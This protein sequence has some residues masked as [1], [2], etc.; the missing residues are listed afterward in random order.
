MPSSV[1]GLFEAEG[2]V[3]NGPVRWGAPVPCSV[4]GVYVVSLSSDPSSTDGMPSPTIARKAFDAWVM[5]APSLTLDGR[6]PTFEQA[7]ERLQTFWLPDET[8]IYIGKTSQPV[9]HRVAQYYATPIGA[10]KPHRGGYWVKLL[11][12]LA[13]CF[14]FFA[15]VSSGVEEAVE[16]RLLGRFAQGVSPGSRRLLRDPS[17]PIPWANLE[18]GKRNKKRHGFANASE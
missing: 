16:H 1:R 12:N 10:S 5:R 14:V 2:I 13:D 11:A 6:A 15:S 18:H 4:P 7:R 17:L 8:V 3:V 9:R